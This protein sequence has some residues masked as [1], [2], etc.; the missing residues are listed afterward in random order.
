M[1]PWN[2]SG[3]VPWTKIVTD[4]NNFRNETLMPWETTRDKSGRCFRVQS[5]QSSIMNEPMSPMER[6]D[7][8]F[9][10]LCKC[11]N[12]SLSLR[13]LVIPIFE[14]AATFLLVQVKKEMSE[15]KLD[16]ASHIFPIGWSQPQTRVR[17]S[18]YEV[19]SN[20]GAMLQ[21]GFATKMNNQ[22]HPV[23]LAC[24]IFCKRAS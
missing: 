9:R 1:K 20:F 15:E 7:F 19:E 22:A 12:S 17:R 23:A 11:V 21:K 10:K 6:L 4:P 24:N 16:T 5:V 18:M 13:A 8:G 2:F 14:R 3:F